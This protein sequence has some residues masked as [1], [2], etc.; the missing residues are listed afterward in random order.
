MKID[1]GNINFTSSHQ[2]SSHTGTTENLRA[3]IGSRPQAEGIAP[4]SSGVQSHISDAARQV[5]Q[6][7]QTLQSAPP[8]PSN[9]STEIDNKEDELNA[10]DP[11][12]NFLKTIIELMTGVPIK[13]IDGHDLSAIKKVDGNSEQLLAQA[14][15]QQRAPEANFGMEYRRTEVFEEHESSLLTATGIIRTT[16]GKEISFNVSL[17]MQRSYQERREETLLI[18]NAVPVRKDPLVINF[19][20]SAAQLQSRRVSFDIDG[21]GQKENT[22]LLAGN[23]GY[24][25]LDLNLNGVVDSGKELFGTTSGDG[26]ADLAKYDGDSNGWIDEKDSVFNQLRVWTQD[27]GSDSGTLS[28]L[29]EKGVGALYLGRIVTPFTLT[30]STNKALGVV[31]SSGVYL[32]EDGHVDTLQQIDLMI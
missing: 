11:N 20:G 19:N 30:D 17:S 28:T 15:A 2:S 22:P 8:A 31:R 27:T 5:I 10:D 3:W 29:K 23:S 18:G 12:L 14:S 25:A 16:D 9:I 6:D 1:T 7:A 4:N 32:A 26:F 13:T 21:D 24:L